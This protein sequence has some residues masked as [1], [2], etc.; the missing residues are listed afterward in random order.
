MRA[1]LP[2]VAALGPKLTQNFYGRL[3]KTHPELLDTFNLQNQAGGKQAKALFNSIAVS[4]VSVLEG[5]GLPAG[6]LEPIN[7]KHCALRVI[8]AQYDVV[9]ANLLASIDELLS[10]PK[11]ALDA[12]REFYGVVAKACIDREEAIYKQVSWP[13][14]PAAVC[15]PLSA[16]PCQRSPV[17]SPSHSRISKV[18]QMI[19]VSARMTRRWRLRQ[20]AGAIYA[21]SR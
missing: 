20:A 5:K 10:P 15:L 9:G 21:I 12:W 16:L 3:F 19:I 8:P 11:D 18:A 4:A 6:A 14:G 2:A 13:P 17:S 7:Q 1:T